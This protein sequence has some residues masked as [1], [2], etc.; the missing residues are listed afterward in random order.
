M[1]KYKYRHIL[2]ISVAILS[3]IFV[4]GLWL[5][6]DNRKMHILENKIA[7]YHN[8]ELGLSHKWDLILRL[9]TNINKKTNI[10]LQKDFTKYL[11]SLL[12]KYQITPTNISKNKDK[13]ATK[14]NIHITSE[15]YM[16]LAF[17]EELIKSPYNIHISKLEITRNGLATIDFLVVIIENA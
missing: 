3:A 2:G 7:N 11:T 6:I 5:P 13:L 12:K 10:V 9:P 1:L 4:V 8:M 14:H 16:V 15:L 17:L